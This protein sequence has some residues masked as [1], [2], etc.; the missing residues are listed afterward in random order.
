MSFSFLCVLFVIP[1][2]SLGGLFW[3]LCQ[4]F[5]RSSIL[6]GPLLQLCYLFWS[7]RFPVSFHSPYTSRRSLC[8]WED[9]HLCQFF[10]CSSVVSEL[11]YLVLEL[12]LWSVLSSCS[13][14][15][16]HWAL[17]LKHCPGT[18][19]LLCQHFPVRGRCKWVSELNLE[20]FVVSRPGEGSR[21]YLGS[22]E[23]AA[24]IWTS[25]WIVPASPFTMVSPLIRAQSTPVRLL[26]QSVLGFVSPVHPRSFSHPGIPSG[27]CGTGPEWASHEDYQISGEVKCSP[28]IPCCHLGKHGSRDIL[29]VALYL[30][31]VV[32]QSKL[33]VSL[34]SPGLFQFCGPRVFQLL[35]KVLVNLGWR[36][37]LW[38]AGI[39]FCGGN[40]SR[41]SSILPSCW[42]PPKCP[43][44][45]PWH[46]L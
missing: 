27:S 11:C 15:D 10:K 37:C 9:S 46:T 1:W 13:E 45:L 26:L 40:G 5:H 16:L 43:L 21:V 24:R 7:C 42:A 31:G 19:L 3:I 14:W 35:P 30:L 25:L 39:Y 12:K 18:I 44:L 29:R 2:T 8:N 23:N 36:S 17:E 28:L 6:L 4:T 32:A 22:V 34:T 33:I 38:I 41:E 20:L